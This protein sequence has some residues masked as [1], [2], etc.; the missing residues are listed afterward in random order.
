M[1]GDWSSHSWPLTSLYVL[2]CR[3]CLTHTIL[4]KDSLWKWLSPPQWRPRG[5]NSGSQAAQPARYPLSHTTSP[6]T[7]SPVHSHATLFIRHTSSWVNIFLI[8]C[9][10]LKFLTLVGSPKVYTK[11]NVYILSLGTFQS[12]WFLKWWER[13]FKYMIALKIK[14]VW[15]FHFLL[16]RNLEINGDYQLT[17]ELPWVC[18]SENGFAR[19]PSSRVPAAGLGTRSL[20]PARVCSDTNRREQNIP[21][22]CE[23]S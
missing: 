13:L 8:I 1:V 19:S 12:N 7:G 22:L 20:P 10:T 5:L 17:Q 2:R 15:S 16:S 9:F 11:T 14:T 6:A 3:H 18:F 4:L 23:N 21:K